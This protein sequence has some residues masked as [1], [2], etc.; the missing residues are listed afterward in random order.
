MQSQQVHDVDDRRQT[1]RHA[2]GDHHARKRQHMEAVQQIDNQS[3]H[4]QAHLT[5]ETRHHDAHQQVRVG[6]EHRDVEHEKR[7]GDDKVDVIDK[8][9]R[10]FR[11]EGSYGTSEGE[12]TAQKDEKAQQG[13]NQRPAE[14]AVVFVLL[15]LEI[16]I[17]A[18]RR[19]IGTQL[20]QA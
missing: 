9:G 5:D 18:H 14:E 17:V 2:E 15:V 20:G 11:K 7:Q 12:E 1:V 8:Q 19:G 4:T 3:H 10:F 6:L 13:D 16:R